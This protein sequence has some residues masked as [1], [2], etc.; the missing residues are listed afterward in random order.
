MVRAAAET[1]CAVKTGIR[2]VYS[3]PVALFS[4]FKLSTSTDNPLESMD[5]QYVVLLM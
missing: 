3:G 2:L 4:E 5:H 1:N